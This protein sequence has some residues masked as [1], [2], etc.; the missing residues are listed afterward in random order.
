[1]CTC[2]HDEEWPEDTWNLYQHIERVEGLNI[3]QDEAAVGGIFKPHGKR[4]DPTPFVESD[5]DQ[6]LIVKIWFAAPVNIRRMIVATIPTEEDDGRDSHPSTVRCFTGPT[7]EPLSF[8]GIEDL[9]PGQSM[10]LAI[11]PEAEAFSQCAPK[12]FT[13]VNFL[14]LHFPQN[15]GDAERTRIS[16]IGLQGEHSHAKRQAVDAK[17]ELVPNAEDSAEAQKMLGLDKVGGLG[18]MQG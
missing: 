8:D 18:R 17:Y 12:T 9:Q 15:H 3:L 11:N 7:A 4:L 5:A 13:Q 1:M 16:Y 14:L 6:E 2:S 10:D